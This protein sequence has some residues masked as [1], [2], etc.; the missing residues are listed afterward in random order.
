M[1]VSAQRITADGVARPLN[2]V[3]TAELRLVIKNAGMN[4][5]DLG[6]NLVTLGAGYRLAIGDVVSVPV[7]PGDRL[8]VV[9]D[10]VATTTIEVLRT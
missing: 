9:A 6:D 4:P 1:A 5:A 7:L 3:A 10:P 8:H 2:A